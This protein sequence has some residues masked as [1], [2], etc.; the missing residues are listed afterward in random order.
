MVS[1]YGLLTPHGKN[2]RIQVALIAFS[3]GVL[4][5]CL[6]IYIACLVHR[7]AKTCHIVV[8]IIVQHR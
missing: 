7:N 6:H 3:A 2:T 1:N 5:L 4:V 8:P